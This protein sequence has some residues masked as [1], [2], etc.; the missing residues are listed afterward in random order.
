MMQLNSKKWLSGAALVVV[1]LAFSDCNSARRDAERIADKSTEVRGGLSAWH[2]VKSMSMSGKVDAGVPRSPVKQAMAYIRPANERRAVAR[3]ALL[4]GDGNDAAKP[5]QLP[6]VMEL[7]RPKKT[8]LEIK[9]QGQTAVQVYDGTR[10]F[11]LRPFLGR[12]EVEPYTGEELRVAS[13][14]TDL[15]G[16]LIDYEAKGNQLKLIGTESV[17]GRPAYEIEVTAPDGQA[18]HVWVDTESYLEVKIDGTR[19][20]DGKLRPVFTYFRD[21]Q[22]VGGLMVAHSLE[23][24]VEG[25]AGSEKIAIEHVA[26]NPELK[27]ERFAKLD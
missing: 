15:D 11:K 14:Q 6:F 22:P 7:K 10:G 8:R 24:T 1:A 16:A 20:M 4:H 5:V 9:F 27:D 21:Y 18:R 12:H 23:T 19:R 26:L 13:Q 3:R 2:A 25:V 17:N